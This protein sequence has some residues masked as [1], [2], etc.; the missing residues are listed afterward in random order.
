MQ[1]KKKMNFY[2]TLNLILL[3]RIIAE[4]QINPL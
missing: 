2:K 1:N 3:I 4:K